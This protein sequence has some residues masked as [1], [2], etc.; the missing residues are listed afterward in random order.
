[1]VEARTAGDA[2]IVAASCELDSHGG[3]FSAAEDV[4]TMNASAFRN[5]KLYTVVEIEHGRRL[6]RG[7]IEGDIAVDNI[8]PAQA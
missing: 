2:S 5:D 6:E 4:T 1:M 8:R 7:V 3:R